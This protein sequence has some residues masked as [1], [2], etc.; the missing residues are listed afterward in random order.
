[1][2]CQHLQHSTHRGHDGLPEPVHAVRLQG[3]ADCVAVLLV[4]NAAAE[5]VVEE[6]LQARVH[7]GIL[8]GPQLDVVVNGMYCHKKVDE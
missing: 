7:L 2:H 6:C 5:H 4:L 3:D 1:M 8:L